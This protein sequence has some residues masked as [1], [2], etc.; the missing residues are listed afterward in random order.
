VKLSWKEHDVELLTSELF[1]GA[2]IARND[3][4]TLSA[5]TE[6]RKDGNAQGY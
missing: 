6:P 5:A 4:G 2:Q 3:G 1:G